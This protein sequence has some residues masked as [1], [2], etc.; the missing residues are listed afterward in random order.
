MFYNKELRVSQISDNI[1]DVN[2]SATPFFRKRG[3][4]RNGSTHGRQPTL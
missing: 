1:L 2:K 3:A 4:P